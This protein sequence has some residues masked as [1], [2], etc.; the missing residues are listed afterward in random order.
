MWAARGAGFV[1][2]LADLK[3]RGLEPPVTQLSSSAAVLDGRA[4]PD[5]TAV[6][7]GHALYGLRVTDP[8]AKLPD[9]LALR[10]VLSPHLVQ[11][12]GWA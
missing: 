8:P 2:L 9:G 12:S 10:G 5:C 7:V 6:C 4:S 1:Q 3:T 11:Q